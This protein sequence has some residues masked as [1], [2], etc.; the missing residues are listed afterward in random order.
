MNKLLFVFWLLDD[1][2]G[3]GVGSSLSIILTIREL[4][5]RQIYLN[6]YENGFCM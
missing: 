1:G 2:G 5:L 4:L 3:G 6:T